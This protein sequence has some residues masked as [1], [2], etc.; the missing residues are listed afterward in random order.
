M[1]ILS[2]DPSLRSPLAYFLGSDYIARDSELR[3]P[4][5]YMVHFAVMRSRKQNKIELSDSPSAHHPT[6]VYVHHYDDVDPP[7]SESANL[8]RDCL[9]VITVC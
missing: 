6:Y 4:V 8:D 1:L 7:D 9:G 2:P 5:A 3:V